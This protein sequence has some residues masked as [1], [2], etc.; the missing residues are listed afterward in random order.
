MAYSFTAASSQYLSA[1]SAVA[2]AM[3]LTIAAWAYPTTTGT[4]RVMAALDST[5][6]FSTF[7]LALSAS[8]QVF[9]NASAGTGNFVTS[10]AAVN[11]N[12]WCHACGVFASTSS[13]EVFTNG[14]S[15]ASS[16]SSFTAPAPNGTK[17]GARLQNGTLGSQFSGRIAEVGI[18]S[19]ALTVSEIA[20]LARGVTCD[21]VRPQSLVFYAPLIRNIG[22]MAR[23]IALTN[24]NTATVADHPRVYA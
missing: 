20:S 11:T 16:A 2:S 13:R 9:T 18:W 3:P 14:T 23:G 19:A 1:S 5:S 7:L 15:T 17:I 12:E 21:Q 6:G 8:N 22:D 4:A 24:N 10:T